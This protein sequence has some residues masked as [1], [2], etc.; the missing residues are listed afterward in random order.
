M[1]IKLLACRGC[2]KFIGCT[3]HADLFTR[4]TTLEAELAEARGEVAQIVAWLR[5][6]KFPVNT[7]LCEEL[8]TAIA[9]GQH[10]DGSHD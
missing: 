6:Q 1:D 2:G 3:C 4:I 8:A 5:G 10:K 9:A 7:R